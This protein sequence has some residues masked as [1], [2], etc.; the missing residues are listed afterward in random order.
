MEQQTYTIGDKE[1]TRQELLEFGK[2][3]YPKFYWIPRGIGLMFFA[4]AAMFIAWATIGVLFGAHERAYILLA[5]AGG[6]CIPGIVFVVI[7]RIP[8]PDEDYIKHAIDYY[9]RV[10]VREQRIAQAKENK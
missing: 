3:H 7:S 2:R 4:V 6:C 8:K 9:T 10:A 1:Y 5:I